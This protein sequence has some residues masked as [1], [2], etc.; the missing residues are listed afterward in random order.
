[1]KTLKKNDIVWAGYP[2]ANVYNYKRNKKK[3]SLELKAVKQLLW[4][5]WIRI[6][7]YSYADEYGVDIKSTAE[8]NQVKKTPKGMV[9]VRARNQSG[10]MHLDDLIPD[11]LLEI[12]FVDVGQGDGA[13]LVTP[14]DEKYVID[15][16]E[17]D[18]MYRYLDWRFAGFKGKDDFDGFIISH[19]DKDHY[20]GFSRIVNDERIT[21][22]TIWHNGLVEQ[23]GITENGNQLSDSN[24]LLGET[25]NVNGQK[26]LIG[27]VE[28]DKE[29]RDLLKEKK[30]WVKKSTK[31]PKLF[32]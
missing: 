2:T 26:Y 1:M 24:H 5:D 19:P 11:Q 16:G 31:K 28:S 6:S 15:A 3:D 10:Y 13:L 12:V 22:K 23:F 30:R 18:N 29:L 4:G 32:P 14:N 27:L 7:D 21:A 20:D 9:P 25:K 17:F 8:K